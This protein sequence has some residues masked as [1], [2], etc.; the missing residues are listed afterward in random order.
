MNQ[1]HGE[2]AQNAQDWI[3]MS[4]EPMKPGERVDRAQLAE[5]MAYTDADAE[6]IEAIAEI[7]EN[8]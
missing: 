6:D 4:S 3:A 1:T 8:S 5:Q 7:I 2:H